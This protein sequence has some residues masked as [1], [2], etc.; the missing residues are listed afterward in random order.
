MT[1]CIISIS[2]VYTERDQTKVM[3][4]STPT[5][6]CNDDLKDLKAIANVSQYPMRP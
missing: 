2:T 5:V 6:G 4:H 3:S 1:F